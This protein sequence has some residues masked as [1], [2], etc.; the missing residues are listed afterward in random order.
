M[1]TNNSFPPSPTVCHSGT[2]P[3]SSTSTVELKLYSILEAWLVYRQSEKRKICQAP[4]GTELVQALKIFL[5]LNLRDTKLSEGKAKNQTS[6][7]R[8][9]QRFTR[10]KHD[11]STKIAPRNRGRNRR[12]TKFIL[13][14]S[15]ESD[16]N[17]LEEH[18]NDKE[19]IE[20]VDTRE[21]IAE[22]GRLSTDID[23]ILTTKL[24]GT[25]GTSKCQQTRHRSEEPNVS[26]EHS[27]GCH[28]Y[29]D[30]DSDG[31]LRISEKGIDDENEDE[32][33]DDDGSFQR[34]DSK[35][36]TITQTSLITTLF[37]N[38]S[39]CSIQE[40]E[41]SSAPRPIPT[42][43]SFIVQPPI[44]SPRTARRNMFS[45][46]LPQSLRKQLIRD[47]QINKTTIF[48]IFEPSTLLLNKPRT[49]KIA[50]SHNRY[51]DAG[52]LDYHERGW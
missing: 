18:N 47:R 7:L 52:L 37:G 33:E 36:E 19:R 26:E 9:V 25:P 6:Q 29:T 5:E 8:K 30:A 15:P 20:D 22:R 1:Q 17:Q 43:S 3:E 27:R 39:S 45:K 11:S 28:S 34:I 50:P 13:G 35:L 51:F 48:G 12:D 16:T 38:P 21:G 41:P 14:G 44:L 40:I 31:S 24:N 42:S 46:E 23:T 2:P 10:T 32:W 49:R 4:G